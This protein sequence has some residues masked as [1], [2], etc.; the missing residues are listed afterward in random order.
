MEDSLEDQCLY[1]LNTTRNADERDQRLG[2]LFTKICERSIETQG[3][4]EQLISL[5]IDKGHNPQLPPTASLECVE[6]MQQAVTKCKA[7]IGRRPTS[8]DNLE[9]VI[10]VPWNM[11]SIASV[12][13]TVLKYIARL[14]QTGL[15]NGIP[16]EEIHRGL[17]DAV[18]NRPNA[19]KAWL[20]EHVEPKWTNKDNNCT[21][22]AEGLI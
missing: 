10:K 11:I 4:L 21:G 8:L 2:Q 15:G 9:K 1:I 16:L 7:D 17:G 13:S 5:C 3:E 6:I 18:R 22:M 12:S 14:A 20:Q 19:I